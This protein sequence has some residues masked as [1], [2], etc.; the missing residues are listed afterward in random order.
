MSKQITKHIIWDADGVLLDSCA[1][2][3]SVLEEVGKRKN[4]PFNFDSAEKL[5][6]TGKSFSETINALW[7]ADLTTLFEFSDA[8]TTIAGEPEFFNKI[9]LYNGIQE[10][11]KQLQFNG[12]I[13]SVATARNAE[14]AVRLFDKLGVTELRHIHGS[15]RINWDKECILQ[16]LL[17][18]YPDIPLCHCLFVSDSPHD[19][20][21]GKKL[22]IPTCGI[23]YGVPETAYIRKANPTFAIRSVRELSQ[24]LMQRTAHKTASANASA[25]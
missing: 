1:V 22:G 8:F 11:L 9:V 12:I 17:S 13:Q 20:A 19:I 7:D 6:K 14:L 16:N 10:L 23:C 5:F 25:V 21:L 24:F 2:D 3:L 18:L 4:L 15:Q